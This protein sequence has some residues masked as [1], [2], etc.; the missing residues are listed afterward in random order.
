MFLSALNW[1]SLLFRVFGR[2]AEGTIMSRL[3]KK[4]L[5]VADCFNLRRGDSLY[6]YGRKAVVLSRDT[7]HKEVTVEVKKSKEEPGEQRTFRHEYLQHGPWRIFKWVGSK[8]G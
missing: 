2:K 7:R 6:S 8:V 1:E 3:A 5:T 4:K